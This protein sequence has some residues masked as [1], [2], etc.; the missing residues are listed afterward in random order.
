MKE[1]SPEGPCIAILPAEWP[2]STAHE[3][4]IDRGPM[5]SYFA[6]TVAHQHTPGSKNHQRAHVQL[7]HLHSG[8]SAH[9][10]KEK[11]AEGPYSAIWPA[12]WPISTPH[13]AKIAIGPMYSYFAC[14]VAHQHTPSSKNNQRAHVQLFRLQSGPLAFPMK[15]KSPEG[16]CTAILP[17]QWPIST[18]HEGKIT[19]GPMSSYFTYTVTHQHTP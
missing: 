14:T 5:Y 9:P 4:K 12:Q 19:R 3:G 16:P 2:I 8:P 17:A 6:C 15:E 11:S 13:E 1:K 7:F 18:P 10:I